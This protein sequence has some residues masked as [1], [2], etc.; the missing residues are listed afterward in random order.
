[1]RERMTTRHAISLLPA[2]CLLLVLTACGKEQTTGRIGRTAYVPQA[3]DFVS[4]LDTIDSCCLLDE[5]IYLTGHTEKD[6]SGPSRIL[7]LPLTGGE[8]EPLPDYQPLQLGKNVFYLR[9]VLQAGADGTLWVTE[10]VY[11][12]EAGQELPG[13][14]IPEGGPEGPRF[15][16]ALILRRLDGDGK[17]LDCVSA[18]RSALESQVNLGPIYGLM[19][20]RD[21][22][23][24]VW[25]ERGLAALKGSGEVDFTL[26]VDD[27]YYG[28]IFLSD[29]RMAVPGR[30]EDGGGEIRAHLRAVDKEGRDWGESFAL[31][32]NGL[33]TYTG[34]GDALFYYMTSDTLCAWRQELGEGEQVLNLVDVGIDSYSFPLITRLSDGRIALMSGSGY[35][36]A[37]EVVLTLLTPTDAARLDRKTLAYASLQLTGDQRSAIVAFNRSSPDYRIEVTDYSQYGSREAAMTRLATEIGAGRIP[38]IIDLYGIPT[39]RWAANGLLEDLWPWIDG[40]PELGRDAL[41]E[42]VF[43]AAEIDGKLFE[44]SRYFGISTLTGA[45]SVVGD[46]MTWT[47][48]DMWRALEAMPED[49]LPT[50]DSRSTMLRRLMGLDWSRFVDWETGACSFESEEFQVL[51][52]FCAGFP[53]H[54]ARLGELGVYEGRQMLL[55]GSVTGFEFPQRARFLLG[56]DVS[57][58]GYP[59]EWGKVGSSF[60]FVGSVAMSSAC[61][62]KEGAWAFLRTLFLPH[63]E[64]E[65]EAGPYGYFPVN[66]ADFQKAAELAMTPE[67]LTDRDGA[68]VL[69]GSGERIET[70]KGAESFQGIAEDFYQ[71]AATQEDC[72]RILALYD[73]IDTFERW[74]PD[75]EP[76]VLESAGAYFAGDKSLEE[77]A[78][79]IQ[80]RASLYVNENR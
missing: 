14:T 40:D 58:V 42:R 17:E 7:R 8:A 77:T 34:N 22:Q 64:A 55:S 67:Y 63:D 53:E 66:K 33:S 5:T 79:L 9:A 21:G 2:L 23:V 75:L 11:N 32:P 69:D 68:Y 70:W 74:E 48:A 26:P 61:G 4:G 78:A 13:R 41:M 45:R 52:E 80:N 47:G 28:P 59:N 35:T 62:D 19:G 72:D 29:G 15:E 27:G 12:V 60:G 31:P 73:A 56:E 51:L 25:C 50:S 39:A 46:R 36:D 38:D 30:F 44:A 20:D 6:S 16:D 3:V 71:Y 43:Q 18:R 65:I 76:I 10:T 24:W 57:F 37:S 49:C 1:M 54:M